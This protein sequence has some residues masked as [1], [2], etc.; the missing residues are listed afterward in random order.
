MVTVKMSL[1]KTEIIIP[2]LSHLRDHL[3]IP[4]L[5]H[6]NKSNP[7]VKADIDFEKEI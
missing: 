6:P 7:M 4:Y 3:Q 5:H 1:E 2:N